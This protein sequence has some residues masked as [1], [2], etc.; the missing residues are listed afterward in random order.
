M[1]K[2]K[3]PTQ[4]TIAPTEEQSVFAAFVH[5]AWKPFAAISLVFIAVAVFS[6]LS[7]EQER[8]AS[9]G[10]WDLLTSKLNLDLATGQLTANTED[11]GSLRAPLSGTA[12]EPWAIYLSAV[13][14]AKEDDWSGAEAQLTDL[15]QEF[16]D[17]QL[18][19]SKYEFDGA[20]SPESL[21]EHFKRVV[22]D[23]QAWGA[24]HAELLSN[25]SV[26]E[27]APR[28]RI[29][30]DEGP[31]LVGLYPDRAPK[32]CENFLKLCS[33]GFYDGVL[34]HRVI[35]SAIIQAG[36]PNTKEEDQSQWGQGGPGYTIETEKSG[37]FHFEG[38]L[39]A[40]K[41]SQEKESSGSQ[42]FL[43][44]ADVHGLDEQCVAFGTILEGLENAHS[45]GAGEITP[46]DSPI[47]PVKILST[48]VL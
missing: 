46:P 6:M 20:D 17:H 21:I 40:W 31:I 48:E 33:E 12:V 27:Q 43:T 44:V 16:P 38:T 25:P 45:I 19:Q 32:H 5:R 36:D 7:E 39:A 35:P 47:T 8:D 26:S 22:A 24:S 2:H 4:V 3:A 29:V 28:V 23:Q 11:I 30:T 34:F 41:G 14:L 1:A 15:A 37:L 10:N 13:A 42:F 18:N 9:Q